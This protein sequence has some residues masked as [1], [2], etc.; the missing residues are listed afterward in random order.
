[1]DLEEATVSSRSLRFPA[2]RKD[3]RIYFWEIEVAGEPK[4]WLW[5]LCWSTD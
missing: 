5:Y 1:M 3:F 2:F 4:A